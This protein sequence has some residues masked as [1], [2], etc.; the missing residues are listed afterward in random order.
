MRYGVS[1]G[2]CLLFSMVLRAA[3]DQTPP[4][5]PSP[6]CVQARDLM[7]PAEVAEHRE[8]M[9]SLQSDAERAE[10][11][12]VNHEEMKKRA[13]ARGTTLCDEGGVAPGMPSTGH[14]PP[15]AK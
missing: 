7:T 1:I 9:R 15:P 12:R 6:S 5:P 3:A 8:K 10:F 4:A 2:V 11:R 13:A 14:E